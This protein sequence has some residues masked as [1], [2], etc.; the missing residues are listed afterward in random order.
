MKK[1]KY[2]TVKKL[3]ELEKSGKRSI[4]RKTNKK[5]RQ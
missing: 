3:F 4:Y 5:E 2:F 1:V